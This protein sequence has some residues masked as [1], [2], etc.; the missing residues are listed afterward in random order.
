VACT[1]RD[2]E[3]IVCGVEAKELG[4][5]RLITIVR[6]P[7]YA[8]VLERLGIDVAVSPREAMARQIVGL[9][10]QGPIRE[11]S[12]VAGD[13]AE[14]WEVEVQKGVPATEAPLKNLPLSGSLVAA[15]ERK[16]VV[17]VP[18]ADDRLEAGDTV[19]LLVHETASENIIRL[20]QK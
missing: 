5:K 1:G 11:R 13:F 20:F 6:S 7:D 8:N 9:V 4:C 17:R 10:A 3:N 2:E 15:I 16:G 19:V 12:P 18:G 14:I